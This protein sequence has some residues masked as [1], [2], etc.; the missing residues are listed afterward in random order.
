MSLSARQLA[1]LRQLGRFSNELAL[2]HAARRAAIATQHEYLQTLN[3]KLEQ[4]SPARDAAVRDA[5]TREQRETVGPRYDQEETRLS[6]EILSARGELEHLQEQ[7]SR[8]TQLS[9]PLRELVERALVHGN[10]TRRDAG[11][12]FGDDSDRARAEDTVEVG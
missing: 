9:A 8:I 5:A 7:L 11:V 12:A 10:L 3:R 4:V 1:K 2:R 6:Q